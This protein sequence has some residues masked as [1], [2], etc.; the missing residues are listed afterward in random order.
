MVKI[1]A[2]YLPQFHEI[3][4][5]NNWWGKG[6]T[7]WTN[8]KKAKPL[9]KSHNQPNVPSYLGYY[10]L[11]NPLIRENQAEIARNH[12]IYGF[13]YWHYWFGNGKR[14]LERPF[15]EIIEFKKPDFPFC[16]GWANESWQSKVWANHTLD[17]TLIEQLYLGEEDNL[18]HF[19]A[20]LP[21][22]ID[23]RY[24]KINNK[25]LFYIYKPNNFKGIREF[26]VQW[27]SLAACYG[28]DFYFVANANNFKEYDKLIDLG[29]DAINVNPIARVFEKNNFISFLGLCQRKFNSLFFNHNCY[30]IKYKKAIKRIFNEKEDGLENVIPSIVPN[31]DHS[32]R[33]GK[34]ATIITQ[35]SPELFHD[36]VSKIVSFVKSKKENDIIFLKSW[37]EWGEGNYI[38]P[39][40]IFNFEYLQIIKDLNGH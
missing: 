30:K 12:G 5:N 25:N 16:L 26:I 3:E 13:C 23:N 10:D 39:D 27:R 7:E 32:P 9:F 19:H 11:T 1:I 33:S 34:N 24:I 29:F 22:F 31:W 18:N 15:Q 36:L 6:F 8:V 20:L 2:F 40:V 14:L 17:K 21:A 37:N 35:S 4:E 28:F 38:E